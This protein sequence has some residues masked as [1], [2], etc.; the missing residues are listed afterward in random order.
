MLPSLVAAFL[1]VVCGLVAASGG[2]ANAICTSHNLSISVSSTTH[3][4]VH[5]SEAGRLNNNP[6]QTVIT[7][8]LFGIVVNQTAYVDTLTHG[9]LVHNET[10]HINGIL[11]IPKGETKSSDIQ[12]LVHGIG[13]DSR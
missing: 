5:P 4:F 2:P 1:V 8:V 11:C 10:F 9:T 6:N 13:F 7:Q 12:I 3:N